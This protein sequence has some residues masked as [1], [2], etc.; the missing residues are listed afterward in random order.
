MENVPAPP[1]R[2]IGRWLLLIWLAVGVVAVI[3]WPKLSKL[4]ENF[5]DWI[6]ANPLQ[7]AFAYIV[8]YILFCIFLI[9]SMAL[10]LMVGP[11]FGFQIGLLVTVIA[12][13]IGGT[14]A[15]LLGRTLL[16]KRVERWAQD[17]PRFSLINE[18]VAKRAIPIVA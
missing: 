7:G 4:L 1:K 11:A 12:S 5:G 3:Y 16:H 17:K 9:P 2:K 13:N 14:V 8:V 6:Q 15:F 10:S 18:A